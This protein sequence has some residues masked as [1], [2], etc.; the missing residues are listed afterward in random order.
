[1][2]RKNDSQHRHLESAPKPRRKARPK[3]EVPAEAEAPREDVGWVYREPEAAAPEPPATVVAAI[4]EIT[5]EPRKA[6][7]VL[8][9]M[10]AP[11]RIELDKQ[12]TKPAPGISHIAIRAGIG[13]LGIGVASAGIASLVILGFM[14][15]PAFIAGG[16]LISES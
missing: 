11:E 9:V 10:K 16:F 3:F 6:P 4:V 15:G 1:M 2:P 5:P 7:A 14:T 13:L 12:E 8:A